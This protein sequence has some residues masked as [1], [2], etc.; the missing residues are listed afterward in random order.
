MERSTFD[1]RIWG[2]FALRGVIALLFGVLSLAGPQASIAGLSMLFG[3][4][5][6]LDGVFV[7]LAP[8][9][10]ARWWRMLLVGAVGAVIGALAFG[11]PALTAEG[12]L[13]GVGDW[14][15]LTGLLQIAAAFQL[16]QLVPGEWTLGIAGVL[17]FAFGILVA[18]HPADG[19]VRFAFVGLFFILFGLLQLRLAFEL[20]GEQ[21]RLVPA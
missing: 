12:L 3:G 6:F 15:M 21:R 9:R 19:L 10:F 13:W 8:M 2:C 11:K 5:A 1:T 4:Y 18:A 16:R 20:F 14:A 17:S 7:L